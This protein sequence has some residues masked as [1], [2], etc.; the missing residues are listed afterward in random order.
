MDGG[1]NAETGR[2]C[3]EAGATA[4]VAGSS[5]FRSKDMAADISAWKRFGPNAG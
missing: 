1:I 2:M 3:V 5:L 4:L